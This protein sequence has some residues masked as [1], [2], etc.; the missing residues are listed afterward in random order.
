MPKSKI[1]F[2]VLLSLIAVFSFFS[3]LILENVLFNAG[4][5]YGTFWI[6]PSIIFII[7]GALFGLLILLSDSLILVISAFAINFIIF[8]IIFGI[9]IVFL[10][11]LLLGFGFLL[12]AA[13]QSIKEKRLRIKI[14]ISG[15]IKPALGAVFIVLAILISLVLY[16]SPPAQ[17]LRVEL[18]IPRSLFDLVVN[19][20]SDILTGQ[21]QSQLAPLNVGGLAPL[22]GGDI[23]LGKILNKD[24][25]DGMYNLINQQ[26]NF[27]FQPYK[28]YLPYGFAVAAFFTFLAVRF[29]FIWLAALAVRGAFSLMKRLK[30]AG[31]K[32][33]T[34][35]KEIIEI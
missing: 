27:F 6:L 12:L 10:L 30:L 31:I 32:K 19:S 1:I 2:I 24:T 8:S 34:A 16:F 25:R 4:S 15:I 33:E 26:I 35:E 3:W 13:R 5:D 22:D 17:S 11:A 18:K 14:D 28:R 7:T 9:K 29:I 20:M 21:L 23:S